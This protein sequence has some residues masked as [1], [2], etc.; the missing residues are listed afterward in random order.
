MA[1]SHLLLVDHDPAR[2]EALAQA[3][4]QAGYH[5]L[6]TEGVSACHAMEGPEFEY[7]ILDLGDPRLDAG[8]IRQA[9]APSD[10][11]PPDTLE[12]AE[13]RHIARALDFTH[14]NKRRTAHLLGIARSTLLAKVRKYGLD[15]AG[16]G[17]D[18]DLA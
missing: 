13:R 18:R 4:R 16:L 10:P 5:V 11:Q 2:R 14:G 6:V 1:A 8:L 17:A 7:V 12:A 3:L 15:G 9:L